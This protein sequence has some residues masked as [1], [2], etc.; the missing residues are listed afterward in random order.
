MTSREDRAAG[1]YNR[2]SDQCDQAHDAASLRKHRHRNAR[3]C[4]VGNESC[5]DQRDTEARSNSSQ[6]NRDV[7]DRQERRRHAQFRQFF[8]QA[9]LRADPRRGHTP[10]TENER[11]V[12]W[13]D[14]SICQTKSRDEGVHGDEPDKAEFDD[15]HAL[16]VRQF[17]RVVAAD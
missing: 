8:P 13:R 10:P 11:V 12:D 14:G 15:L 16:E 1:E 5:C 4:S 9:Q 2:D 17:S 7:G 6:G 3:G